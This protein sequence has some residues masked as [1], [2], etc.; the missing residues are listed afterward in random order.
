MRNWIDKLL[1]NLEWRW[2]LWE[3][4]QRLVPPTFFT[5]ISAWGAAVTE[6]LQVYSPYSWILGGLIGLALYGAYSALRGYGIR[7]RI[8]A[9]YDEVRLHRSGPLDPM[10]RSFE[11]KRIYIND[12]ILP[13]LRLVEGKTF[14]ECEIIGP[15]NLWI[16]RDNNIDTV[17]DKIDG[18]ALNTESPPL[19]AIGL[20]NCSFRACRFYNITLYFST[21]EAEYNKDRQWINWITRMPAQGELPS[22]SGSTSEERRPPLTEGTESEKQP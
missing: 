20:V 12:L 6:A 14:V 11:R 5:A 1:S 22:H 15:A 18:V 4:L 10:A 16:I 7:Q 2:S 9:Q 8:L 21:A 17:L 19:S 13:S 3:R